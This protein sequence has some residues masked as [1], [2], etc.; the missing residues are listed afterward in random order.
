MIFHD[1]FICS[2]ALLNYQKVRINLIKNKFITKNQ[3]PIIGT[4]VIIWLDKA[5]DPVSEFSPK[6]LILPPLQ[7]IFCEIKKGYPY[8]YC[9]W[10]FC[11]TLRSYSPSCSMKNSIVSPTWEALVKIPVTWSK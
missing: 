10:L 7:S 9:E 2:L 3:A 6:T 4:K 5:A 1:I 8:P 11:F